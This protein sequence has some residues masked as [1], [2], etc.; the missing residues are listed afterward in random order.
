[1]AT[2][3]NV[4]LVLK[5]LAVAVDEAI[6]ALGGKA[7]EREFTLDEQDQTLIA[8]GRARQAILNHIITISIINT[9]LKNENLRRFITDVQDTPIDEARRSLRAEGKEFSGDAVRRVETEFR[10]TRRDAQTD[11]K[12]MRSHSLTPKQIGGTIRQC[13][14]CRRT[15]KRRIR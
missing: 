7:I 15:R 8:E 13:K 3:A 5:K 2:T 14:K 9:R 11:R 10:K 1:M 4:E 6:I 12:Y